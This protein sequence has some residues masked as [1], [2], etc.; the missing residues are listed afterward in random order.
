[1]LGLGPPPA[2]CAVPRERPAHEGPERPGRDH[3]ADRCAAPLPGRGGS[4]RGRPRS[5]GP[6][7]P[8][9]AGRSRT[10]GPSRERD[11]PTGRRDGGGRGCP[12]T[13]RRA[14]VPRPSRRCLR[15]DVRADRE[16]A[17]PSRTARPRRDRPPSGSRAR[18]GCPAGVG[19]AVV[20]GA[21]TRH[22]RSVDPRAMGGG[23]RA[24]PV[25]IDRPVPCRPGVDRPGP[26]RASSPGRRHHGLRQVRVPEDAGARAGT[27]PAA[28]ASGPAPARLQ[29]RFG[30]R[31][32]RLA[33]PL[34]GKPD[35]PVLRIDGAGPDLAAGG[36]AAA[37]TPVR[38]PRRPGPRRTAPDLAVELPAP[39]RRGDRRVPGAERRRA[40]RWPGPDADRRTRTLPG[41]APR[42]GHAAGAG[43]GDT[44]PEGEPHDV[45]APAGA[46]RDGVA[47]PPRLRRGGGDPGRRSGPGL[48]A[49]RERTA[50]RRA[51]RVVVRPPGGSTGLAG[52]HGL[53][54]RIVGRH[55]RTG[56]RRGRLER[57]GRQDR[58]GRREGRSRPRCP[59]AGGCR[60]GGG[61]RRGRGSLPVPAGPA[62]AS[63][64]PPARGLHCSADS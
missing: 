58:R 17:R 48:P 49:P 10:H 8:V 1:M 19:I 62:A 40:D 21:R 37:G 59:R 36:T 15:A 39:A 56:S 18:R 2:P 47:G 3:R 27:R 57:Q 50:R 22:P 52:R 55:T 9:P 34:R 61:R 35:G 54:R 31:R 13:H 42:A 30:A 20:R 41:R 44:G 26:G 23:R 53:P 29:G 24:A 5:R 46:D 11:G 12:G 32:T 16:G 60:A 28:R 14:G 25:G 43:S 45:G 7:H 51:G 4:S 63:Q 6:H 64:P 38:G 33:P